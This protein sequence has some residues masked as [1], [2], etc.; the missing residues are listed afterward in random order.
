MNS[1]TVESAIQLAK[2]TGSILSCPVCGHYD[3]RAHDD[4]AEHRPYARA[5]GAR[6]AT[7]QRR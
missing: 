5:T 2:D 7:Q 4:D 1:D 3:L 6:M